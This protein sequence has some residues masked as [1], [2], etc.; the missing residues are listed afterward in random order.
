MSS[1]IHLDYLRRLDVEDNPYYKYFKEITGKGNEIGDIYTN[2][3]DFQRGY[4]IIIRRKNTPNRSR[5]GY[6]IGSWFSGLFQ[7]AK[8]FLKKGLKSALDVGAKIASDVVDGETVKSAMKKRVKEKVAEALPSDVSNFVNK[9]IGSGYKGVSKRKNSG[10]TG[11][12]VSSKHKKKK[13]N[14][15][16]NY[17]ALTLIP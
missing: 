14:N 12:S 1:D 13:K 6:G 5:L 11:S 7:F 3:P 2:T 16:V 9:A 17:P 10:T 8:P 4:G 15:R